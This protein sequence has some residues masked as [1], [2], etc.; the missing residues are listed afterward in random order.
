MAPTRNQPFAHGRNPYVP[1]VHNNQRPNLYARDPYDIPLVHPAIRKLAGHL[2]VVTSDVHPFS[3]CLITA[4]DINECLSCDRMLRTGRLPP[5]FPLVY[6]LFASAFNNQAPVDMSVRFA[7]YD[8]TGPLILFVR[9]TTPPNRSNFGIQKEHLGRGINPN[10][11]AYNPKAQGTLL[12]LLMDY[13]DTNSNAPSRT[14][15][16]GMYRDDNDDMFMDYVQ[17]PGLTTIPFAPE[18]T[19]PIAPPS[20]STGGAVSSSSATPAPII[21]VANAAT[22]AT[23]AAPAPRTNP[24]SY[25]SAVSGASSS[26]TTAATAPTSRAKTPSSA[27]ARKGKAKAIE[28]VGDDDAEGELDMLIDSLSG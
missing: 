16:N 8:P 17:D 3:E 28:P 4:S 9:N 10:S 7:M 19:A 15:V 24:I 25:A 27:R 1:P 22:T 13:H 21:A 23:T 14:N 11:I 5:R 20:N 12:N 6:N 2:F 18:A 26:S